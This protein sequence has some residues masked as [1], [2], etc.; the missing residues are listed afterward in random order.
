[1]TNPD[2]VHLRA[3]ERENEQL[4]R[5]VE[6]LSMLNEVA[7][8]IG[9]ARAPEAVMNAIVRHA[10]Q[11]VHAEQGVITLVD[12]AEAVTPHTLVRRAVHSSP[13]RPLRL[14]DGLL[15]WMHLHKQPLVVRDPQRDARFLGLPWDAS[16]RS[17]LAVPLL[18]KSALIGVL[19]VFNKKGGVFDAEDQRLLAILAAQSAQIIE[20]ARLWEEERALQHIRSEIEVARTIQ[21]R[22]LPAKLPTV[23]GYDLAAASHSAQRV[24][25]DFYDAVPVQTDCL[26]LTVGDVAG[27]G[28]PASLMMANV[29]ATMRSQLRW[30]TPVEEALRRANQL[31]HESTDRRMFVTL[32]AGVLDPTRHTLRYANAG[33]NRPLRCS[34]SGPAC[35]LPGGGLALGLAAEAAYAAETVDLVIG[36]VL[37][38]YS[39]GLSEA[40]NPIREEL[41]EARVQA[42]LE[43]HAHASAADILHHVV[44]AAQ[45]HAGPAPPSD[46]TTLL[47]IKRR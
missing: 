41:G 34:A 16:L 39:D 25:G 36:D 30:G 17:L 21:A 11:A 35:P 27:K 12:P 28:L 15:G 38:L 43:Q 37:L 46:D 32:F 33:H 26:A 1:M 22:L 4:R 2:S 9:A 14:H 47:V 23:P 45:R 24:G 29:Q 5:A 7:R 42:L 3:L 20:N 10:L 31:L 40:M 6:E 18:V 8:E 19:T 13:H 44:E